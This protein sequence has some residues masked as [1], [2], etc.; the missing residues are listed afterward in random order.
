MGSRSA[1]AEGAK[2]REPK[3]LQGS[4]FSG[5]VPPFFAE[6]APAY[7]RIYRKVFARAPAPQRGEGSGHPL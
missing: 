5:P 7:R 2:E 1:R 6:S 4:L 3:G